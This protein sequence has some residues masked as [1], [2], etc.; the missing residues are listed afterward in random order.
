MSDEDEL[1]RRVMAR[2]Q[3]MTPEDF[4]RRL[5]A[6]D[7]VLGT[8]P[9][10][11]ELAKIEQQQVEW[12]AWR[13]VMRELEARSVADVN[14]GGADERLHDAIVW[15]GEELAQLRRVDPDPLHGERALH[16]RRAKWESDA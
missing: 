2:A 5:D 3:Q 12:E 11:R 8:S 4:Y 16:E 10:D 6:L 1:M 9:V 13:A 14:A 15:W 7:E